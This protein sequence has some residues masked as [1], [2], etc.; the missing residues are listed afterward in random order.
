MNRRDFL[1]ASLVP[2]LGLD[3]IPSTKMD[4]IARQDT[5]AQLLKKFG[6]LV[7]N[8][9]VRDIDHVVTEDAV[10]GFET[11]TM[12]AA[13]DA[14]YQWFFRLGG[15][16][17]HGLFFHMLFEL[18]GAFNRSL[19]RLTKP[20]M[21]AGK[22]KVFPDTRPEFWKTNRVGIIATLDFYDQPRV[23]NECVG[24]GVDKDGG[25]SM[26]RNEKEIYKVYKHESKI[27]R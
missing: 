16:P 25:F 12:T 8:N 24:V 20:V 26:Y 21:F 7:H 19:K 5:F 22:I 10:P 27:I 11:Y 3:K 17:N 9:A 1:T 6:H 4:H 13:I 18:S 15:E 23:Q 14:Q 2:M